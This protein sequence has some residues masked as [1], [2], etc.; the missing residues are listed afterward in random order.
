MHGLQ[1]SCYTGA[2]IPAGVHDVLVIMV[3]GLVEEGL[4]AGLSERPSTGIEWLFLAPNNGFGIRVHIEVL[5]KLLPWEGIQLLNTRDGSVSEFVIGPVLV[6]CDVYL[7]GTEDDAV[8]ILWISDGIAM[9]W[10]RDDPSE[11][12]IA[13]E[14][15]NGGATKW[16]SKKRLREEEDKS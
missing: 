11:M 14:L 4:D 9:F 10:V 15:F 12:G 7:A 1:S 3:F 2:W 5:L 13:G 6:Q 8:D 16:M